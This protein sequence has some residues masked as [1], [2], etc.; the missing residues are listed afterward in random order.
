[1]TTI[2]LLALL[3]IIVLAGFIVV[4]M[5]LVAFFR[6][7]WL[8]I[9]MTLAAFV[10]SFAALPIAYS[11][12]PHP[13]PPL[14]IID[15]PAI[16]Y[17]GLIFAASFVVTLLSSRYMEDYSGFREEYYILIL[18]ASLGSSVLVAS[19]HF[20]PF[21]L[22]LETLSVALY[23]LI[24][25]PH[26]QKYRVEA[27]IKYLIL[28]GVTSAFMLFGM[29][30]IYTALG[31]L[32]F[33]EILTPGEVPA[34]LQDLL[35]VGW[36]LLAVG[37]GF[38]LALVPFQLWTPDVYQGAPA[39]VTGF[40]ASVSKGGMFAL[41]LRYYT[42]VSFYDNQALWSMF[43]IIAIASML[44]GN[45]LAL[46]QRNVKRVLAY[47]SI[48]HLGYLMVAF[49]ASGDLSQQ[50]VAFYLIA[51]FVTI[52]SAFGVITLLSTPDKETEEWDA[53][54]GLFWRRPWLATIFTVSL[55]SLAGIPPSIGII[56]KIY[57][58]MAGVQSSLWV[59]L[60]VLVA[61]SVIGVFYYLGLVITM[62]RRPG[63]EGAEEAVELVPLQIPDFS[64]IES[65]ALVCL[66][67]I[68]VAL[69]LYPGPVFRIIAR[70]IGG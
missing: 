45:I 29:A 58:A 70:L 26:L 3:P 27:A 8:T 17:M 6:N 47:S 36:G 31:T 12:R 10:A 19:D 37:F 57:L 62:F 51:Y 44:F 53:Y 20:A 56:G 49:L 32:G 68:I 13:I 50:A 15:G 42:H 18:L 34:D 21:F 41:L 46:L 5:L 55:I 28:A 60:G 61:G 4:V 65:T 23:A 30:L 52:L 11:Y 40:I 22:G 16:F 9:W 66:A 38:K 67:V 64:R 14:L 24:A 35:V 43:A 1:M 2:D 48:S 33:S 54:T 25:Y 39:P 7:Y 69:G 59:L 63:E